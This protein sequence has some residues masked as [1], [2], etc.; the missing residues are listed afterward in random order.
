MNHPFLKI[1][2]KNEDAKRKVKT[3]SWTDDT[4]YDSYKVFTGI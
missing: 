3:I 1:H 2:H 4:Q